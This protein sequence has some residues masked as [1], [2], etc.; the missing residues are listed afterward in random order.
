ML[1]SVT[2]K[3][4]VTDTVDVDVVI[5]TKNNAQAGPRE[6]CVCS[7]EKDVIAGDIFT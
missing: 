5:Q 1:G 4:N 6:D 3:R 7:F 2:D